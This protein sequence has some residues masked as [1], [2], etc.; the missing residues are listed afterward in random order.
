MLR[1]VIGLRTDGMVVEGGRC[2]KGSYGK[3]CFCEKKGANVWEYFM[4]RI[5]NE[6]NN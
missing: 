4:E 5:I 3:L 2:M 6:E 1:L